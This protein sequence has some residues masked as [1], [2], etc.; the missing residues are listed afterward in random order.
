MGKIK[1]LIFN[2]SRNPSVTF[3]ALRYERSKG[4]YEISKMFS[5]LFGKKKKEKKTQL[6]VEDES[7]EGST[8]GPLCR[9][10]I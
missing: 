8:A 6:Q 2:A 9:Y 4:A 7:S 3:C 1:V 10:L 5:L